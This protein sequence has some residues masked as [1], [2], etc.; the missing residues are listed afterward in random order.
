MSSP[1]SSTRNRPPAL[2]D[3]AVKFPN[4]ARCIMSC[5]CISGKSRAG[6]KQGKRW[7]VHSN[8][9]SQQLQLT[10][11]V[12]KS[13]LGKDT[14]L[15]RK[16]VVNAK[17]LRA[18][19]ARRERT[20]SDSASAATSALRRREVRG[21]VCD[22]SGKRSSAIILRNIQ[23]ATMWLLCWRERQRFA[24]RRGDVAA[25]GRTRTENSEKSVRGVHCCG[26][27]AF[28]TETLQ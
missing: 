2:M 10:V 15:P 21:G 5:M 12:F 7:H 11:M 8:S 19:A 3:G 26:S 18:S 4:E 27:T 28:T 16:L 14:M 6:S 22:R 20:M 23:T 13:P 9:C 24:R 17:P 1:H 25:G